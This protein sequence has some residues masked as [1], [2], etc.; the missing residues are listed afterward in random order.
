MELEMELEMEVEVDIQD[1]IGHMHGNLSAMLMMHYS[2][3]I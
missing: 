2:S 1:I 3:D